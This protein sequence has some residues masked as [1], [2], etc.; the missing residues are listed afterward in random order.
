M[1]NWGLRQREGC[2]PLLRHLKVPDVSLP[3]PRAKLQEQ[4]QM[5]Q[6]T[7]ELMVS[8]NSFFWQMQDKTLQD[9]KY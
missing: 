7:A 1:F 3:R 8:A 9:E 4:L 5:G 2:V 6:P